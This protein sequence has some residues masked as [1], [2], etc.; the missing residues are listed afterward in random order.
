MENG[1]EVNDKKVLNDKN[2]EEEE[3]KE[4]EEKKEENG[5]DNKNSIELNEN[6]DKQVKI[7]HTLNGHFGSFLHNYWVSNFRVHF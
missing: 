4:T 6:I 1:H 3:E 7:I 5:E 2:N